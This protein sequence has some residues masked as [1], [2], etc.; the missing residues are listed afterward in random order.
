[1]EDASSPGVKGVEWGIG[2]CCVVV[3]GSLFF[4]QRRDMSWLHVTRDPLLEVHR[5]LN[6]Y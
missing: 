5:Q 2:I 1:M 4:E 6:R 3:G